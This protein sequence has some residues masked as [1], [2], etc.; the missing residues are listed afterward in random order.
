MG[1]IMELIKL[2]KKGTPYNPAIEKE[3]NIDDIKNSYIIHIDINNSYNNACINCPNH[4]SNGG[5]GIC[6]C[7][8]ANPKIT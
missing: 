7:I 3:I 5:S 6:H 4:F 2:A 8:L 1:E